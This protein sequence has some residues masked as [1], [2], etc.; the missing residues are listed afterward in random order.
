MDFDELLY[1]EVYADDF[2]PR[3]KHDGYDT[4]SLEI[5]LI[6]GSLIKISSL[7]I[8]LVDDWKDHDTAPSWKEELLPPGELKEWLVE[9]IVP[10]TFDG[11]KAVGGLRLLC[12]F[13]KPS[14]E[15]SK[16]KYVIPF[17]DED[18]LRELLSRFQLPSCF[19]HDLIRRRYVPTRVQP[20]YKDGSNRTGL[21]DCLIYWELY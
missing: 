9:T 1:D 4:H 12:Q 7:E 6:P 14:D 3:L 11:H 20:I 16:D 8:G 13:W 17:Q 10:K 2:S 19:P 18:T 5:F 15:I 21:A